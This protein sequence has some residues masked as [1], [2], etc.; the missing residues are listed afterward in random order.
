MEQNPDNDWNAK[1]YDQSHTFVSEYGSNLIK[2]LAPEQGEN[3]LDLGCGTG[4]LTKKI[5]N[6][7]ANVIGI[8]QSKSMIRHAVSKY[9]AI[10]FQVGDTTNLG[11]HLKFDAVFSNATLHWIKQP[12]QAL[13][14]IYQSLKS[15]GR[16]VAE[17]G[18]KGNVKI[19]TDEIISQ[20]NQSGIN[21]K[22]EQF[23]WYF[24]SIGEYTSLM[25]EIGFNVRFATHF[26]RPTPLVGEDGLTNWIQMF[27]GHMLIKSDKQTTN[28]IITNV[29]NN[30]KQI[31]YRNGNWIADYKRIR[32]VGVK[33]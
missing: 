29:E 33:E 10:S 2:L 3:I 18:G 16:F 11:F 23:P 6:F 15:G 17:F 27:A 22:S 1:L 32:V 24:P 9:P 21:F 31:L 14:S 19:I 4:D 8:D 25:E 26:E 30:L 5:A 7:G 28:K 12:K 20:I 13:N